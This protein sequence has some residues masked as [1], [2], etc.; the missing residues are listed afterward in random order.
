MPKEYKLAPS[1]A[2][3]YSNLMY[4]SEQGIYSQPTSQVD[5]R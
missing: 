2:K 1:K 5:L 4:M 3:S